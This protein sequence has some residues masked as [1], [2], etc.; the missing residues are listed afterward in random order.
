M[1]DTQASLADLATTAEQAS[2]AAG[3][4]LCERFDAGTLEAEYTSMDVKTEADVGAESRILAILRDTHP[5][6]AISTEESGHH[7]GAG[8][9]RWVVDPL[10]GTNNFA[11]GSPMFA[12]AVTAVGAEGTPDAGEAL[13]TALSVPML[14]EQY[15]ATRGSD[16]A[17]GVLLNDERARVTDGDGVTPSQATVA[18][19][20]GEP[21]LESDALAT[22]HDAISTAIRG[23]TKRLIHTWAPIVYWGLLA[24]GGLDGFVC[25]YPDEREQAAGSLVA[26]EAGCVTRGDGPLTVFARDDRLADVLWEA[27]TGAIGGD[28]TPR[29]QLSE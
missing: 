13:A 7:S 10:D 6:H 12:V 27:A 21:V 9:V 4:Y 20:L 5:D 18:C 28:P 29:A 17:G 15:V 14:D 26:T 8:D 23:E 1:S 19:V 24:K 25:F 2:A 22:D 16:G 11:I 3:R